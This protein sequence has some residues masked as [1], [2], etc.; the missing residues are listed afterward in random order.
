MKRK[1]YLGARLILYSGSYGN[2][3][4]CSDFGEIRL[5]R[6]AN[7]F[8]SIYNDMYRWN[9]V[10]KGNH[11]FFCLYGSASNRIVAFLLSKNLEALE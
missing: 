3:I 7:Q 2:D 8:H 10:G 4:R 9:R 6:I 11:Y 1:N 5:G